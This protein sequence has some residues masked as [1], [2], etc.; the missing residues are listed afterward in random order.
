MAISDAAWCSADIKGYLTKLRKPSSI[1]VSS[2]S[3]A[4][5]KNYS[6]TVEVSTTSGGY[7]YA[8]SAD[9]T[10]AIAEVINNSRVKVSYVSTGETDITIGVK[11]TVD[12]SGT[13]TTVHVNCIVAN[14]TLSEN[15]FE[16]ISSAIK[17]GAAPQLWNVGDRIPVVLNGTVGAYTFS[18]YTAY[19]YIIGFDHNADIEGT[20][21]V[22]FQFAFNAA[23]G[24]AHIAFCDSNYN[25]SGTGDM[26]RMNSSNVNTGGWS[27]SY[28]RKTICGQFLSALPTDL[29]SV[30]SACTKYTDNT[31]GGSDTASYVTSTSDKI[32]L[33]SEYEIQGARSYANS[34]E[35]NYQKQYDYYKNGNSKVMYNHNSTSSAVWWWL[36]SPYSS[37]STPF[38]FVSADGSAG[39]ANASF[40]YGFAPCFTIA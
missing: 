1:A 12:Y 32:F 34:A 31:G 38:C 4:V 23:S 35:K 7:I 28:M 15:S 22:H 26:F 24:G 25:S 40:S 3:I 39:G 21:R 33:P 20:N 19:A 2:A 9:E 6:F 11:D 10:I 5:V 27:N 13:S 37:L 29:Q 14:A 17:S 30:I 8:T 16:V 18:N 36:R